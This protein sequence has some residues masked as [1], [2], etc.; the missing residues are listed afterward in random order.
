MGR[1]RDGDLVRIVVDRKGLGGRVDFVGTL[2]RAVTAEEGA[3]IL[4]RR[5]PNPILSAHPKLPDDT[6]LW[7]ALQAAGGGTWGGCVY[8]TDGI[9]SR[10]CAGD[11]RAG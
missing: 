11:L 2:E 5:D 10:L 9:V 4:S 1:L 8:D 3:T 6:R 7:A